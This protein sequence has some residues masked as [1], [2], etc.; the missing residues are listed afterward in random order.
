MSVAQAPHPDLPPEPSRSG[1]SGPGELPLW[2]RL[3]K[4]LTPTALTAAA[5]ARLVGETAAEAAVGV[6]VR[7]PSAEGAELGVT[8]LGRGL[9]LTGLEPGLACP[10][11]AQIPLLSRY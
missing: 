3:A 6:G 7:G 10:R 11:W 1:R 8:G 5:V 4:P 2:R 9:G